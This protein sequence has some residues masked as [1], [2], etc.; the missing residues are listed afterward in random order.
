MRKEFAHPVLGHLT[1]DQLTM[2]LKEQP[3]L[4]LIVLVPVEGMPTLDRPQCAAEV[5]RSGGR[6]RAA[7][8]AGSAEF[9]R[10]ALEHGIERT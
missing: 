10:V 9:D 4:H 6:S 8:V 7:C 1:V 5:P 2:H 3:P